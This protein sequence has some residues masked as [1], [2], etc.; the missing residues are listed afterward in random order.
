M[1]HFMA[2]V[3]FQILKNSSFLKFLLN[4]QQKSEMNEFSHLIWNLF[5]LLFIGPLAVAV[6]ALWFWVSQSLMAFGGKIFLVLLR[7]CCL[8]AMWSSAW[9]SL[10][11]LEKSLKGKNGQNN[12][13]WGFITFLGI[14]GIRFDRHCCEWKYKLWYNF[15]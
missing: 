9:Q 7:T 15:M 14:L 10:I 8:E 2:C 3:S 12:Q 1:F 5:Y 11:V 13:K 4:W 6:I